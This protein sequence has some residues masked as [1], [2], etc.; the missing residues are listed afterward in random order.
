MEG[1]PTTG[2]K[3]LEHRDVEL[4]GRAGNGKGLDA[5]FAEGAS[6]AEEEQATA[7]TNAMFAMFSQWAQFRSHR[8]R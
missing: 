7:T 2:F 1:V 4:R 6:F 3:R 8:K 5:E